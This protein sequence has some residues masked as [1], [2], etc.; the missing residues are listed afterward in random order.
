[1]AGRARDGLLVAWA[2]LCTALVLAPLPADA[3]YRGTTGG[4]GGYGGRG[5]Y[6]GGGLGGGGIG[7]G[8]GGAILGGV[9]G[10]M[11]RQP[12]QDV[13]EDDEPPPRRP[14]RVAEPPAPQRPPGERPQPVAE[15]PPRH[16]PP[17]A[18]PSEPPVRIARPLRPAPT[19]T[20]KA[21]LHAVPARTAAKPPPRVPA[22][23]LPPSPAPVLAAQAEEPG[24]VPGE[25]LIELK[26]GGPSGA[27]AQLARQQRLDAIESETFRLVPLTLHR[28][29][30]RDGRTV[31]A[32]V[33]ALQADPQV[34]SAQGN[35]VYSLVGGG[36]PALPFAS[37]Q[38]V[39][40]K[41]HLDEAHRAATGRGVAIAVIDSG[42]DATHP[43][44]AG[45]LTENWD[46]IAKAALPSAGG[47]AHGTAV[48][49]IA[50]ARAQ[51]ASAAPEARLV[52]IRAFTGG[53]AQKPGSQG[54]TIHVLR[55]IDRA[56][57]AEARVVNM[58]FAGPAD[59][60]LSEFL[61][62]GT[63][64]G[65]VYVAAAGNAGPNALP[66]YPAADPNV[67][68][69]TATDA[70]D[71]LFPAANRGPHVFVAAPGVEV[72]VATPGGGYGFLSG[73]SMAAP[74]VAGIAAMMLQIR[75]DL[76]LATLRD[77]LRKSAH[78]LG[79]AGIDPDFGAGTADARDA[80][81]TIGASFAPAMISDAR[82]PLGAAKIDATEPAKRNSPNGASQALPETSVVPTL[83]ATTT[84][85]AP[86][87]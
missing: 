84:D 16:R 10:S 75:P 42:V 71:K 83:S 59:A 43:A 54:T 77:A 26:P 65:I 40:A 38:Y 80:L 1:M 55:A 85:D 82:P 76:T 25:V 67:I 2:A 79:P 53:G 13:E 66:L 61:A 9:V 74:Q 23:V 34:A 29:R 50:G 57:A 62:A 19:R 22:R 48:A 56:A 4:Y 36:A 72:F 33:R 68:A 39:V 41:L 35:H 5:G 18:R 46:A 60:K 44:L 27:L 32:V 8:I 78:D 17:I 73:T 69:V 12:P 28:Y 49:G 63:A 86:A 15:K 3:Q 20:V 6:G 64:K 87:K 21:P 51:L 47:D 30:I 45:A 37:A 11:G 70:E 24:I 81:Q 7:L 31:A 14:G 52:A 58:S